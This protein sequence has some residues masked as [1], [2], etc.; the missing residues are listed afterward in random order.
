MILRDGRLLSRNA[1][2]KRAPKDI[3]DKQIIATQ[4]LALDFARLYFR[5]R[6]PTQYHVEGIRKP[7]EYYHNDPEIHAPIL[8][9]LIFRSEGILTMPGVFFS[10]GNMQSPRTN[11]LSSDDEFRSLPF[12][13]IYHVGAVDIRSDITRRRC[14]EVLVPMALALDG[15][16]Q[17]V[18]CRSPA[19]R[20]TL[21]YLLGDAAG[22]WSRIIRVYTEP[23][24]FE[25]RFAYVDQVAVSEQ[26]VNFSIHHRYDAQ[27]VKVEG[28]IVPTDRAWSRG[29]FLDPAPT[30]R[31][32]VFRTPLGPGPYL[33]E[34]RIDGCLAYRAVS[35]ID[36]LPF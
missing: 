12:E 20:A 2:Q 4:S 26:G 13:Q 18:L 34:I 8:I 17:A 5:P 19:E 29:F 14:A 25:N 24:I 36:E 11:R 22:R 28:I 9:I 33:V 6:S 32:I 15:R 1:A 30:G 27:S 7:S 3:A 10:D 21:L 23:G 16:L 31:S 35:L